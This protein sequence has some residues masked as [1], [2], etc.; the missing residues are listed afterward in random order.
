MFN[1]KTESPVEPVTT[2]PAE[3]KPQAVEP[4]QRDVSVI[5]PT[6]HFKGELSA[7]E[8]LLIEGHIEG[9]IAHQD[10]NLTVGTK[11]RVKADIHANAVEVFG[12]VEG[13]IKG[14]EIIRIA[15]TARVVGNIRCSRLVIEDGAVFS[16]QIEMRDEAAGQQPASLVVAEDAPVKSS[17]GA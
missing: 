11:G 1:K 6:V 2:R 4:R 12:E 14:D 5:G 16:G 10:K 9:F 15:K 17:A 3:P 7:N 8:D 13:D